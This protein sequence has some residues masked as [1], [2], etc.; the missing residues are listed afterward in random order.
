MGALN[1]WNTI[2]LEVQC[3]H[4]NVI[5]PDLLKDVTFQGENR[6]VVFHAVAA[7]GCVTR[8]MEWNMRGRCR[9]YQNRDL[10]I[11]NDF[12]TIQEHWR[13]MGY[14]GLLLNS[15]SSNIVPFLLSCCFWTLLL[16]NKNMFSQWVLPHLDQ[17]IEC[18]SEAL[19]FASET[20]RGDLDLVQ[21]ALQR[22]K[23]T[24]LRWA[25]E[26]LKGHRH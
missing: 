14:Y 22:S 2:S 7:N 19:E 5:S 13:R 26:T 8:F 15:N 12:A 23:G 11:L 10:P 3:G 24:A 16:L 9:G 17:P 20:L 4:V 6:E 1:T 18:P 21:L 25:N